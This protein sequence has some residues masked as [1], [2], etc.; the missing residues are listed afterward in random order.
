[1][2]IKNRFHLALPITDIEE[3][4]NFYG[5]ILGLKEMRSAFNWIDFDFFGHQLS[6]QIVK[7][8]SIKPES[9]IIDGD[10]VPAMHFGLIVSKQ[11]WEILRDLISSKDVKFLIAPKIRFKGKAEEQGT[12]FISDPFGNFIEI[13]YFSGKESSDWV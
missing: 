6:L 12:Y 13:K 9:T 7:E 8:R 5:K 2:K 10:Q 3:A 1:M 4:R 11:D